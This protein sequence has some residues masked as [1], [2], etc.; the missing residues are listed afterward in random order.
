MKRLAS[1]IFIVGPN[2]FKSSYLQVHLFLNNIESE[3]Y[4]MMQC[5]IVLVDMLPL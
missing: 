1:S 2:T 3:Y 5:V 4:Q